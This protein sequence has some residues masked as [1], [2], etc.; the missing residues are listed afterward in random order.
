MPGVARCSVLLLHGGRLPATAS[1]IRPSP[2][3][4]LAFGCAEVLEG[5]SGVL[6]SG[7][8]QMGETDCEFQCSCLPRPPQCRRLPAYLPMYVW[9]MQCRGRIYADVWT[10]PQTN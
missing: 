9:D 6:F 4:V 5:Q 10:T 1:S 8:T 7:G 3:L 2:E